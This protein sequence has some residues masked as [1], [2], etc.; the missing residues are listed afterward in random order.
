MNRIK[1][2]MNLE[3]GRPVVTRAL[4]SRRYAVR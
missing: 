4:G 3:G 2:P 1:A